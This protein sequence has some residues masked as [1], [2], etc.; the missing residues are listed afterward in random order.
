[1]Y[2]TLEVE[3]YLGI[4]NSTEKA[5]NCRLLVFNYGNVIPTTVLHSVKTF[6]LYIH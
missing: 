3:N 4:K 2:A 5:E 1:M 6:P